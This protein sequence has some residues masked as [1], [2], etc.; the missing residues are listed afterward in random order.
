MPIGKL[1]AEIGITSFPRLI[2][3]GDEPIFINVVR[4][5]YSSIK[6]MSTVAYTSSGDRS[7]KIELT[8]LIARVSSIPDCSSCSNIFSAV[9][10]SSLARSPLPIPSLNATA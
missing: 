5:E 9:L 8:D 2:K 4:A 3:L 6:A 7:I 1:L 10:L